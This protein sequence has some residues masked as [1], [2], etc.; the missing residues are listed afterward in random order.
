MLASGMKACFNIGM[1]K[2]KAIELL[3][4]S[5]AAAAEAVGIS[6]QA[7][8]DWPDELP[9]RISQRVLGVVAVR[10]YPALAKEASAAEA[11]AA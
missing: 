3:G 2:S 1:L 10:R 11:K 4:G 7:V 5:V 8:T 9:K 6:Y